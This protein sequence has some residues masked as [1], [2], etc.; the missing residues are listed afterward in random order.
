MVKA[1]KARA[2]K[3]ERNRS[4][5]QAI[6]KK[7]NELRDKWVKNGGLITV[8]G[9]FQLNTELKNPEPELLKLYQALKQNGL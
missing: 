9:K 4:K 7:R 2:T 5:T 8:N 3:R 6:L 1:K